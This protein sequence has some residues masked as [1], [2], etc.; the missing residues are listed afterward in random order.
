MPGKPELPAR[1]QD[2]GSL[3]RIRQ[4]RKVIQQ[5]DASRLDHHEASIDEASYQSNFPPRRKPP[6]SFKRLPWVEIHK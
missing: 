6:P 1:M 5:R 3:S 4:C 2:L